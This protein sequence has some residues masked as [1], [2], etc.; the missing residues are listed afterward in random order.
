MIG[1]LRAAIELALDLQYC[2]RY[3]TFRPVV[4]KISI[5][6]SHLSG[7]VLYYNRSTLKVVP[8]LSPSALNMFKV[9]NILVIEMKTREVS[10]IWHNL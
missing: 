5:H 1:L 3:K 2:K 7:I 4:K 6:S 9:L 10:Q 8:I